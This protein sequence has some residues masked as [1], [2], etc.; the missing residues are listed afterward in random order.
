MRSKIVVLALFVLRKMRESGLACGGAST[1]ISRLPTTVEVACSGSQIVGSEQKSGRTIEK[2]RGRVGLPRLSTLSLFS[3]LARFFIRPY[4]FIAWKG[5]L[6][7]KISSPMFQSSCK[8]LIH[9][10]FLLRHDHIS[11][12]AAVSPRV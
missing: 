2:K 11:Y 1:F 3:S 5:L 6:L 7:G 4:Y 10:Y 9:G 8:L 12:H